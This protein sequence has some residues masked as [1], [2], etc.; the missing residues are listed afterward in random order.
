MPSKLLHFG[1]ARKNFFESVVTETCE[2]LTSSF[3]EEL[4]SLS[5]QIQDVPIISETGMVRRWSASPEKMQITLYRLPIQRMSRTEFDP[6]M[7]I[8]Q[9]VITAAAALID[10]DPWEL[11][12]PD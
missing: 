12:H 1:V 7:T 3:P 2:Y 4:G 6:R 9:A 11:I 8:E 5:W 10:K